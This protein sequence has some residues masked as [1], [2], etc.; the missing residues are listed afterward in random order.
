[1]TAIS[2]RG[3]LRCPRYLID[4]P[5]G[6]AGTDAKAG[7]PAG[8]DAS[9]PRGVR[10]ACGH[11]NAKVLVGRTTVGRRS[12][13]RLVDG[14]TEYNFYFILNIGMRFA[15]DGSFCIRN[16]K[17][18]SLTPPAG[19]GIAYSTEI[20]GSVRR[21]FAWSP[22]GVCDDCAGAAPSSSALAIISETCDLFLLSRSTRGTWHRLLLA[23]QTGDPD[24]IVRVAMDGTPTSLA[25]AGPRE[26]SL[27]A[28]ST[29]KTVYIFSVS[30][31]KNSQ[32]VT[33]IRLT[34]RATCRLN[35]SDIISAL[36]WV[37]P[38]CSPSALTVGTVNGGA[39]LFAWPHVSSEMISSGASIAVDAMPSIV[40]EGTQLVASNGIILTSI[41]YWSDGSRQ[42]L[43][44]SR[45]SELGFHL[46][47]FSGK[48]SD[49]SSQISSMNDKPIERLIPRA[50]SLD[51]SGIVARTEAPG[52]VSFW[53]SSID[54]S[55]FSWTLEDIAAEKPAIGKDASFMFQDVCGGES[56][57]RPR[58]ILGITL[59]TSGL[60]MIALV[61]DH[62]VGAVG[63]LRC[64]RSR[65]L[66]PFTQFLENDIIDPHEG[67]LLLASEKTGSAVDCISQSIAVAC[68]SAATREIVTDVVDTL[69][70]CAL[71]ALKFRRHWS[72]R[73]ATASLCSPTL[74]HGGAR[75]VRP[76]AANAAS[77]TLTGHIAWVQRGGEE[78]VRGDA[79]EWCS[80]FFTSKLCVLLS[81]LGALAPSED[82]CAHMSA[83]RS[84]S[85][86]IPVHSVFE[87]IFPLT[88]CSTVLVAANHARQGNMS[89][90]LKALD[91]AA[92]VTRGILQLALQEYEDCEEFALDAGIEDKSDGTVTVNPS[93]RTRLSLAKTIAGD[94][95]PHVSLLRATIPL[96]RA[97]L[98]P[99]RWAWYAAFMSPCL[100]VQRD[101][102]GKAVAPMRAG[103]A[104]G[105]TDPASTIDAS[106]TAPDI[107]LAFPPR[108]AIEKLINI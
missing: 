92:A 80:A 1:M 24:E 39:F 28:V 23:Y 33:A 98:I 83:V 53:S 82:L 35:P 20:I 89:D 51:I 84:L 45:G 10:R 7:G 52:C 6:D 21:L 11:C 3:S 17:T 44:F 54:G 30:A 16:G 65:A 55:F 25:W 40:L 66:L 62:A 59:T 58:P 67:P 31:G 48:K 15:P 85:N 18:I 36:E 108:Y 81:D 72:A 42:C 69:A 96:C 74:T 4:L 90:A 41:C 102:F 75:I 13:V 79:V 43:A 61:T 73:K 2:G 105:L 87:A 32:A 27:L 71:L 103:C 50:H 14:P 47:G 77:G 107:A 5:V 29:Q 93:W 56:E 8:M 101:V 34:Q 91:I 46:W 64:V 38:A 9:C 104:I 22:A 94:S 76:F 99:P 26:G 106:W 57:N 97:S 70:S 100:N 95:V 78:S 37:G 19:G 63:S 49:G 60:F 68:F 12:S 88:I 86:G